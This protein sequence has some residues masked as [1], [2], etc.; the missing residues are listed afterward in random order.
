MAER[1][2][3]E[4]LVVRCTCLT[5]VVFQL[6]SGTFEVAAFVVR[7]GEG[8]GRALSIVLVAELSEPSCALVIELLRSLPVAFLADGVGEHEQ[9]KSGAPGVSEFAVELER[10]LGPVACP[11]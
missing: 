10:L 4:Q 11:S 1:Y 9:G 6:R 8:S 3:L 5:E 7:P 2:P